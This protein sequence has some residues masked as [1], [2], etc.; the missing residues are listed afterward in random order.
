MLYPV[1]PTSL[2]LAEHDAKLAEMQKEPSY[3][4]ADKSVR[5]RYH[6]AWLQETRKEPPYPIFDEPVQI[7]GQR[8][9]VFRLGKWLVSAGLRLQARCRTKVPPAPEAS[10]FPTSS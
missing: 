9:L 2:L 5:I 1:I 8:R 6:D 7:R 3:P 10:P 4:V